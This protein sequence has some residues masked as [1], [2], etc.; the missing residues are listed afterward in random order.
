VN[1]W[2]SVCIAFVALVAFALVGTASRSTEY[3]VSPAGDDTNDGHSAS[4]AW[5]TIA[6]ANAAV[7]PGDT[8]YLRGGKYEDD[9]VRP[10]RSGKSEA[11]IRYVAY[12]NETPVLTSGDPGGLDHAIDLTKRSHIVVDGIHVDG[13]GPNPASRVDHFVTIVDGSY[14]TIRNGRFRYATGWHGIRLKRSHHNRLLDNVIDVVG[15]Y[16]DGN[17]QDWGDSIQ[18]DDESHHNLIAGNVVRRG[19]HNLLQVEG[20][21]NVIRDNVFDNDWSELLGRG[22]G[23]RNL[24][25]MGRHN[26]FEHNVVRHAKGSIDRSRNA[27]MKVEGQRNIVRRNV[28]LANSNEGITSQSRAGQK[29]AHHN[30]I[31]HNTLY[32]N[33]GPAWGLVFYD[34]GNGVTGNVFK[35][36]I[37]YANRTAA[38]VAD[39]DIVFQL[40]SNPS[41]VIGETIIENNLIAR[42]SRNDAAF[43]V[44]GVGVMSLAE[45]EDKYARYVRDNIHDVPKFV[46]PEP[47]SPEDF[48]LAPGSRGIDEGAPL[49]RT[50]SAGS[51][52]TIPLEDAGYFTDGFSLVDGDRIRIGDSEP[53][54]VI[55]VDYSTHTVTVDRSTTWT[56]KAPVS[57]DFNGAGPDIGAI[58]TAA[59]DRHALQ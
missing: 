36:N 40:R 12:P 59:A 57:L 33:E 1:S 43:D 14:N 50:R 42:R 35:N 27:G 3:F 58:E 41:G 54:M 4:S 46:V 32:A 45:A 48:A 21:Y 23:G 9:P 47:R 44:R 56:A 5:R 2:R 26:V 7:G 37:V 49:T 18:I 34:G 52:K 20:E 17:G 15:I 30:R 10:A 51:G 53:L 13:V 8:V 38:G 28:I 31:Y 11:P 24:A 39:G 22:K 16:D 25:L 29:W 6:K 19:A 55:A